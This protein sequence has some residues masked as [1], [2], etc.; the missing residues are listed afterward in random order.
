MTPEL[1]QDHEQDH[2]QDYEQDSEQEPE[3]QTEQEPAPVLT[4]MS[5]AKPA[6]PQYFDGTDTSRVAIASWIFDVN[7][8]LTLTKAPENE[9]VLLAASY[10][11]GV[12]KTWFITTY[13]DPETYPKLPAFLQEFKK[14]FSS[15]TDQ[16]DVIRSLERMRIADRSISE[17]ISEFKLLVNQLENQKNPD[18]KRWI[19][20]CF[21]RGL[22]S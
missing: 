9:R 20:L 4:V 5:T 16:D 18:T 22:P 6:K 12:A 3:L 10:L 19:R 13:D 15:M 7:Q 2:E 21:L 14:N 11:S 17:Y 8:Y 1:E